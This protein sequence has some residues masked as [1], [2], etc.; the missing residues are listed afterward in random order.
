LTAAGVL[1]VHVVPSGDVMMSFPAALADTAQNRLSSDDQQTETHRFPAAL[2]LLVH[3]TASGD[4]IARFVAVPELD[5][6]QKS[7]SSGAQA[8][9]FQALA[10][11]LVRTLQEPALRSRCGTPQPGNARPSTSTTPSTIRFCGTLRL[12]GAESCCT[13]PFDAAIRGLRSVM[14][15]TPMS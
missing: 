10:T 12:R 8:T 9:E 11:A 13:R 15:E 7:P 4:V 14:S 6:A 3:V 5:T 1:V 2:V